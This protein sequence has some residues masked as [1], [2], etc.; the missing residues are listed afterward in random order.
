ML[1][2][3]QRCPFYAVMTA[4]RHMDPLD[5]SRANANTF[6]SVLQWIGAVE[7]KGVSTM[8]PRRK[9]HARMRV[10]HRQTPVHSIPV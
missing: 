4:L 9:R 1:C 10:A 8:M 5:A 3:P 7:K 6:L 2:L